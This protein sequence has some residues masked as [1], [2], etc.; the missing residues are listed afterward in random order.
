MDI[1][2]DGAQKVRGQAAG[3]WILSVPA[4]VQGAVCAGFLL[5]PDIQGV[6][7]PAYLFS[8]RLQGQ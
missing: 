8:P 2:R 3:F 6:V 5:L 4:D 7:F 1:P